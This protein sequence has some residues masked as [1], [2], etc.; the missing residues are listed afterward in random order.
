MATTFEALRFERIWQKKAGRRP[1]LVDRERRAAPK[2]EPPDGEVLPKSLKFKVTRNIWAHSPKKCTVI[3]KKMPIG[4]PKPSS[5][6][7]K[8]TLGGF[9]LHGYRSNEEI[10]RTAVKAEEGEIA[11]EI[12][13][14]DTDMWVNQ[15]ESS[16]GLQL[17]EVVHRDPYPTKP[18]QVMKA[19]VGPTAFVLF[20]S[21]RGRSRALCLK[22]S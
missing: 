14:N 20:S 5:S 13:V 4:V 17:H 2:R 1:D 3:H 8:E 12:K 11:L 21:Q 9:L 22:L 15:V 18:R 19:C 6:M 10:N 7:V 16:W